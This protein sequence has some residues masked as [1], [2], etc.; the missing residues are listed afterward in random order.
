M[1][2]IGFW[3]I[4]NLIIEYLGLIKDTLRDGLSLSFECLHLYLILPLSV[5]GPSLDV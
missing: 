4:F 5:R 2:D 3:A 1:L